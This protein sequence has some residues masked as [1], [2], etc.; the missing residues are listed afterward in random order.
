MQLPALVDQIRTSTLS[1]ATAVGV[2]LKAFKN[3][4]GTATLTTAA[5]D[6]AGAI[7]E[8]KAGAL[9]I[10]DSSSASSSTYSSSKV[11]TLLATKFSTTDSIPAAQISGVLDPSKIPVI[12]FFKPKVLTVATI[13]AITSGDQALITTDGRNS[14]FNTITL[15]DGS[16]YVY[17]GGVKT[18]PA[19][20]TLIS[21]VTP[22][23]TAIANK[24]TTAAGYGITDVLTTTDVGS[25][26]TDFATAFTTGL[27]S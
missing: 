2:Q 6:H 5:Q 18:D 12:S 10:N 14:T 26:D 16:T 24:P 13:G 21:D 20:Y 17:G 23:F 27:T 9:Q 11:N 3:K 22:D 25:P 15:T 19:S 8:L 7:N 1:L 4:Q